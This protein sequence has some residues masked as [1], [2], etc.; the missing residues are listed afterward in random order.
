M[1]L[2]ADSTFKMDMSLEELRAAIDIERLEQE[3]KDKPQRGHFSQPKLKPACAA[4]H[5]SQRSPVEDIRVRVAREYRRRERQ[6]TA[7]PYG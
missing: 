4:W 1:K 2:A 7:S 5:L 6:L 3:I